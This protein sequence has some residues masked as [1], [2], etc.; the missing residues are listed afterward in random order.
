[1]L[2]GGKQL[3]DIWKLSQITP[4]HKNKGSAQ[5]VSNYR[6]ISLTSVLCKVMES[7][8]FKHL[9]NF[10]DDKNVICAQF[11]YQ[12]KTWDLHEQNQLITRIVFYVVTRR[13]RR[14][15][16]QNL[17]KV[18]NDVGNKNL[19]FFFWTK[20]RF[21]RKGEATLSSY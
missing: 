3:P 5:E 14:K 16:I 15:T 20:V 10:M 1:M 21:S 17:Q 2:L 11:S 8:L 13:R 4:I 19:S 7:I 6:P 18:F 12:Q 9:H